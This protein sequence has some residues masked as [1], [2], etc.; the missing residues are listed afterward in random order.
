[1]KPLFRISG[2]I[3][4]IILIHSCEDKPTPPTVATT[5]ISAISYTT[6]TSGGDATDEGGAPIVSKGVCWNTSADPTISNT[7]TTESGGL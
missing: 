6:A 3:L 5:A 4:L 2:L 7:K 1:M